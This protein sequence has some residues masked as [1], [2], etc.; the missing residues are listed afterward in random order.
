MFLS[1]KFN[2]DKHAGWGWKEPNT[3]IYLPFLIRAFKDV[4]YIHVIRN[5]LDMAFSRNQ[6]QLFNWGP[7]YGVSTDTKQFPLQKLSLQYWIKA[8]K[9]AIEVGKSLGKNFLVVNFDE[10][11]LNPQENMNNLLR[12]IGIEIDEIKFNELKNIIKVPA[13]IGRFRDKNLSIFSEEE[14]AEVRKLGFN[15]I[16]SLN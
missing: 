15:V 12:F 11:C 1:K 7:I 10:L 2:P 16:R 9:K 8:N 3:H 13:S 5:G 4:K 6:A 14:I